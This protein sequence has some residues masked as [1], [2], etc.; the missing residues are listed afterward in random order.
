MSTNL[1]APAPQGLPM[2][3]VA[4]CRAIAE[5]AR[6]DECKGWA[7]KA[8][9]VAAYAKM[10][11]NER[12]EVDAKRIRLRATRRIGE[13][14]GPYGRSVIKYRQ[15][16]GSE[17]DPIAS[18]LRPLERTNA[19]SIARI[20]EPI[21]ERILSSE[22][23]P[24]VTTLAGAYVGNRGENAFIRRKARDKDS[25]KRRSS[26]IREQIKAHRRALK[27]HHLLDLLIDR[28]PA[29]NLEWGE[30][31]A[32]A[33]K[34]FIWARAFLILGERFDDSQRVA[35]TIDEADAD[36]ALELARRALAG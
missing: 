3:Y 18:Q 32:W 13:I 33:E 12:L 9:A 25:H 20:P 7:D 22:K 31:R 27:P 16:H 36:K 15:G 21:F 10:V 17:I 24:S 29:R 28:Q 8:A 35:D 26:V 23:P 1:P 4:A 19:R 30:V 5:C 14:I 2:S 6:V 34:H 11:R